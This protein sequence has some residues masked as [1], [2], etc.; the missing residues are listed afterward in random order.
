MRFQVG[1]MAIYAVPKGAKL[2]LRVGD[3][4]EV[5]QIG[6]WPRGTISKR[7]TPLATDCHYQIM[8]KDGVQKACADWQ[9]QKK[10]PPTEPQFLTSTEEKEKI[11]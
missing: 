11:V 9:L 3:E 5:T 2:A 8:F 4:C 6:Y 10:N 7:G 1:E